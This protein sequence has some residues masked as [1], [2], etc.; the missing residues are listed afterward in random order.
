[1]LLGA[2]IASPYRD[3][4]RTMPPRAPAVQCYNMNVPG[5]GPET[6]LPIP[7]HLNPEPCGQLNRMP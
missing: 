1:M 7:T 5:C 6:H 2:G 4:I 3:F